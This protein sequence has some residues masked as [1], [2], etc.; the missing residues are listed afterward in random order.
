[1]I[2]KKRLVFK[3][4]SRKMQRSKN[5]DTLGCRCCVDK[6]IYE[7]KQ[8]TEFLCFDTLFHQL[9]A[10]GLFRCTSQTKWDVRLVGSE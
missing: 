10:R 3:E 6:C 9:Y 5:V 1:M 2:L 7:N 4:N 8:E